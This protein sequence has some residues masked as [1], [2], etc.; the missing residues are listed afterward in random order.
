VVNQGASL[1]FQVRWSVDGVPQPLTGYKA[2]LSIGASK[3]IRKPWVLANS[4]DNP[5]TITMEPLTNDAT[6]VPDVGL[7][8]FELTPAQTRT[9]TANGKWQLDVAGPGGDVKRLVE[10]DVEVDLAIVPS[11]VEEIV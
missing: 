7:M 9:F 3:S 1:T 2:Y 10:G 5:E 4:E 8:T 6:P 11:L